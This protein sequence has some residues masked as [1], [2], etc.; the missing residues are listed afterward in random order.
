MPARRSLPQSMAHGVFLPTALA[1]S[2]AWTDASVI[3]VDGLLKRLEDEPL[4][5]AV[6]RPALNVVPS[7]K[8]GS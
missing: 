1:G 8:F 3:V 7:G 4:E 2:A 5:P 6:D